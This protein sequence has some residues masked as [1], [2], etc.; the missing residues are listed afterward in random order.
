MS[1]IEKKHFFENYLNKFKSGEEFMNNITFLP[2]DKIFSFDDFLFRKF[3]EALLNLRSQ[4][5]AM[6][7]MKE[8]EIEDEYAEIVGQTCV[9]A[10][11]YVGE[12]FKT[13]CPLDGEYKVGTTWAHSH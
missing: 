2:L 5:N 6:D 10:L 1:R 11:K 4:L 8:L 3:Y 7:L 12:M 9:N 13:N